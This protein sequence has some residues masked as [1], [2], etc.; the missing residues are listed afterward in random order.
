MS[1]RSSTLSNIRHDSAA[2]IFDLPAHYFANGASS[3]ARDTIPEIQRLLGHSLA[4]DGSTIYPR[5]APVLCLN[6][7]TSQVHNYFL[8]PCLFRVCHLILY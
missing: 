1:S 2:T 4:E 6:E 3:I 7:D 5:I 8:N